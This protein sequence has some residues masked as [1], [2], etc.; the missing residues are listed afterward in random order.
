MSK[1]TSIKRILSIVPVL[2]ILACAG[3]QRSCQGCNAENFGADW[4][5]VQYKATGDPINCWR[6]R[7][8]SVDNEKNSDGIYWVSDSG[9]L[10]HISGWYNRVQ[11]THGDWS[12]AAKEA[13]IDL[14]RCMGGA[15]FTEGSPR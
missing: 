10:V 5:V 9:H 8:K 13:G 11:V 14:E 3:T 12:G 15:Y 4:L 2:L 1:L 6:L 7:D